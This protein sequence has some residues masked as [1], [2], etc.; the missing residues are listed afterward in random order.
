M[1]SQSRAHGSSSR[2]ASDPDD[3]AYELEPILPNQEPSSP[4]KE[5]EDSEEPYNDPSSTASYKLPTPTESRALLHKLDTHLV[6]FLSLL[7]LLSFLDRSNIGNAR[8]AGLASDLHLSDT[9]YEWLLWAFYITYIAFEWMALLYRVVP[10]HI[11]ISLC[12]AAWGL[13]ASLQATVSSFGALLVLR[14]LLGVSEAA[15]GPGVPFYL[16]FFYRREEL[17]FRTGLFISASPLSASFAGALAWVITKVGE[18]GP[19]SPWRLL[20]LVEGFPS[21]V[22]A[23][24]AWDFVPDG[25]GSARWLGERERWVAVERLRGEREREGEDDDDGDEE[26]HDDDDDVEMEQKQKH[27]Y[28]SHRKSHLDIQQILRTLK[29]PK[30]Y[31]TAVRIPLPLTITTMIHSS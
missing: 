14:G 5:S 13:I 3:H 25:P 4:T 18:G 8:I 28:P 30:C 26:E 20:F 1:P 9:Q 21:L 23:V 15:F 11:Y 10:A 29:D 6:L 24:W 7:Y 31:L 17:A 12:I 16:S 19:L 2:A 22:V 27:A